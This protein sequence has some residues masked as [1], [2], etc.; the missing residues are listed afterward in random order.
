LG[1]II[2][3]EDIPLLKAMGV[4]Q[5]FLPGTPIDQ[6]VMNIQNQFKSTGEKDA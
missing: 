3:D 4:N 5:V 6:I 1:G 2:P